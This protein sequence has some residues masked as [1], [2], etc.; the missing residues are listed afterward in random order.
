[1]IP[2]LQRAAGTDNVVLGAQR[3][4]AE[5]FS[6]FAQEVPGLYVFLGVTPKDKDPAT[7]PRNHSPLFFADEAALIVGV[8]TLA[9]LTVDYML[10]K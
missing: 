9:N 1:M 6:Y 3:T 7:A 5:D 2:T 10:G 4:G 8:R